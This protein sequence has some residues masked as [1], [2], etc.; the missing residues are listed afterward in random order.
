MYISIY[1][2]L[3]LYIYIYIYIHTHIRTKSVHL[4]AAIDFHVVFMTIRERIPP[5]DSL[6]ASS[7][8]SIL[9]RVSDEQGLH[10]ERDMGI[11]VSMRIQASW[12]TKKPLRTACLPFKRI[13]EVMSLWEQTQKRLSMC[14]LGKSHFMMAH[15]GH[16][17]RTFDPD[18]LR[19][20]WLAI[21]QGCSGLK[22]REE[23]DVGD[24]LDTRYAEQAPFRERQLK[25]WNMFR[26]NLEDPMIFEK[27][28]RAARQRERRAM[29][30]EDKG[31]AR[32]DRAAARQSERRA[33]AAEDSGTE[34]TRSLNEEWFLLEQVKLC[35]QT[36]W[37]LDAASA[38]RRRRE[39]AASAKRRRQDV[40]LERAAQ[41]FQRSQREVRWRAM[42]RPDITVEEMMRGPAGTSQ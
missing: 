32:K 3:S 1:I 39:E 19:E 9:L 29:A 23:A 41:R 42:N 30:A 37:L 38:K 25:H 28:A 5:L 40:Q 16:L 4:A 31:T 33:M 7:L 24:S 27:K 14:W 22:G 35:L 17:F 20:M 18:T 11:R 6:D 10:L 36:W 15:D 26:M 34:L 2:S 8:E 13:H 12:F 21:R